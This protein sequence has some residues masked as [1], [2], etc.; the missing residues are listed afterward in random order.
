MKNKSVILTAILA[1]ALLQANA[2][3]KENK[4]VF[5]SVG[6]GIQSNF[7][8]DS[9]FG[10]TITPLIN[11]SVG[12]LFTPVWGIRGQVYGWSSRMKTSYPFPVT[13]EEVVRKEN[14]FGLN[15]DGMLNLTN[16]FG[17]YK[18]DR[19]W[20]VNFFAGPSMNLGK[21]YGG[22]NVAYKTTQ[23][24]NNEGTTVITEIDTEKTTPV[25]RR[26]RC[27]IGASL[28]LGAKYNINKE[29]AVDLEV[30]G[31]VTPSILGAYSSANNDGYMY[32][33][34]GATYTFGGK[35]FKTVKLTQQEMDE[36]N[37][38]INEYKQKYATAEEQIGQLKANEQAL[39]A[40]EQAL[41]SEVKEVEVA[42][43]RSIFFMIGSSKVDD[44]GNVNIKQA[45]EI[46]KK[47]PDKTYRVVGYADK[48][49]GSKRI[50]AK[51]AKKRAEE[52]RDILVKEGVN[53][54]Q[55]QIVSIPDGENMFGSNK[56]NRVVI[57]E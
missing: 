35:G 40:N 44:Y 8:P 46:I 10:K 7:N 52:V 5:V 3:E 39:K 34:L 21:N 28:G 38:R 26:M 43:P 13:A 45:A 47:N 6:A 29:W 50:N 42:G 56:L 9:D 31:Q 23:T 25:D 53:A 17:G 14:Y 32:L 2:Q 51:L 15:V 11:V 33:N 4:N 49:T 24:S 16:L 55:L 36:I 20:E 22:W 12:K 37:A 54:D 30:R 27:N 1:G 57:I 19:K 41:K 18:A 48:A